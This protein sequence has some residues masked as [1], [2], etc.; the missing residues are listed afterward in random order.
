VDQQERARKRATDCLQ[1]HSIGH[2]V[3]NTLQI[4]GNQVAYQTK[5][6]YNDEKK[7]GVDDT[8]QNIHQA[9]ILSA[10]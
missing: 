2:G 10:K 6:L 5:G 3:I 4:K 8:K 7:N 9:V 1:R